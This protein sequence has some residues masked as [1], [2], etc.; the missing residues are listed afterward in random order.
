MQESTMNTDQVKGRIDE[1]KG[2]AKKAAGKAT[3]NK[4]L[5]RKGNIQKASGKVQAGYGNLKDKIKN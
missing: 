5:E 2:K 3:G 1:E 4:D